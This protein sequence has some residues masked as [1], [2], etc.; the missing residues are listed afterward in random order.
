MA[1]IKQLVIE[2]ADFLLDDLNTIINKRSSDIYKDDV[3]EKIDTIMNISPSS[4][5]K[6][7][8]QTSQDKEEKQENDG[9]DDEENDDDDTDPRKRF[10]RKKKRNQK[11]KRIWE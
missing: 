9:T 7:K 5:K 2:K 8:K 6:T 11:E 3:F 10:F 1:D 4:K